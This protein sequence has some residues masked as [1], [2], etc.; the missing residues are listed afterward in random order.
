[1]MYVA[2]FFTII[3]F[4]SVGTYKS[5]K[6]TICK[7]LTFVQNVPVLQ[8]VITL[9]VCAFFSSKYYNLPVNFVSHPSTILYKHM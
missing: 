7:Q 4:T 2:L 5:T 8:N 9:L 3:T 1:M 6:G